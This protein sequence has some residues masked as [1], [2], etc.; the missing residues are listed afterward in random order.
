MQL[1]DKLSLLHARRE[2][3]KKQR[4][5]HQTPVLWRAQL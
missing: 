2:K 5:F 1:S 4:W 3:A